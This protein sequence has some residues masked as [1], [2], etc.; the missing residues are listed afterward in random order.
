MRRIVPGV[1]EASEGASSS[2]CPILRGTR[3]A[4]N[5]FFILRYLV[6][7]RHYS[8]EVLPSKPSVTPIGGSPAC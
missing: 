7:S 2:S 8:M 1:W 3:R 4:E 6:P 5:V